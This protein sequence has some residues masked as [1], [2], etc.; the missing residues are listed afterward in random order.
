MSLKPTHTFTLEGLKASVYFCIVQVVVSFSLEH[1]HIVFSQLSGNTT[2]YM[3]LKHISNKK[4]IAHVEI[5]HN[6]IDTLQLILHQT[7]DAS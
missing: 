2:D 3:H 5:W 1:Y 6:C 7:I 4:M